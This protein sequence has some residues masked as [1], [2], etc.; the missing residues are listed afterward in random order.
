MDMTI[1]LNSPLGLARQRLTDAQQ[2]H[3]ARAAR[4]DELSQEQARL[5]AAIDSA[6]LETDPA[7]LS[8]T[9]ARLGVVERYLTE[10]RAFLDGAARRL[11]ADEQ[12]HTEL[13]GRLMIARQQLATLCDLDNFHAR[14]LRIVDYQQRLAQVQE[15]IRQLTGVNTS[16]MPLLHLAVV[17][18]NEVVPV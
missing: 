17:E 6:T 10:A 9:Q 4:V 1:H 8:A 16:E 15:Q 3:T 13:S 14:M 11:E 2:N 5:Q 12:R 18:V 7:T